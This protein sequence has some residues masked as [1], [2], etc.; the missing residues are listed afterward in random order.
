[1]FTIADLSFTLK[2]QGLPYVNLELLVLYNVSQTANG[3]K[4]SYCWKFA[5]RG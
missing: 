4:N 1:L 3:V 2:I 5:Y